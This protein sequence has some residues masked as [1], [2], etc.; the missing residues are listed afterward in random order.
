MGIDGTQ[1]SGLDERH[2]TV[3]VPTLDCC[4][5]GASLHCSDGR[6][7]VWHAAGARERLQHR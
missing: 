6:R 2:H 1:E 5:P 3:A 7:I 4:C